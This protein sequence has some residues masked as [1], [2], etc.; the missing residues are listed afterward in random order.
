MRTDFYYRLSME[1]YHTATSLGFTKTAEDDLIGTIR[2]TSI[3]I[4]SRLLALVVQEQGAEGLRKF[5]DKLILATKIDALTTYP[6]HCYLDL[7]V[8]L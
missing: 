7:G 4:R 6:D 1:F 2:G 5:A 3:T 8:D